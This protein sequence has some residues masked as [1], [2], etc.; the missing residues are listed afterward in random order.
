MVILLQI[1]ALFAIPG[2]SYQIVISN[3]LYHKHEWK[4]RGRHANLFTSSAQY[5]EKTFVT[6]LGENFGKKMC[7]SRYQ[8]SDIRLKIKGMKRDHG[9][10]NSIYFCIFKSD[11]WNL[12][13]DIAVLLHM[14]LC[15][16][17]EI[18]KFWGITSSLFM[19]LTG[20]PILVAIH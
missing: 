3:H 5:T 8:K 7:D 9:S 1:N 17:K 2:Q 6:S 11:I 13:S 20:E 4:I 10:S 15:T 12:V 14:C 16:G 19:P 18:K